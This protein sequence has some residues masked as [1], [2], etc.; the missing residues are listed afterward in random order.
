MPARLLAIDA[1]TGSC[2]AALFTPDGRQ[3]ALA[4]REWSHPA[5]RGV[6]GGATFDID[7][8]WGLI[9]ACV[10]SVMSQSH[11]HPRD[12][13]AVSATSMREGI[14]LYD[15]AGMEVWA[16]PNV[17]ARA[18]AEVAELVA[19]GDAER[20]Y[21]VAGDWVAITSAARLLWLSTH[22]PDV[23]AATRHVT[24]I[25]DWI[26]YRL[27]AV[28]VTDPSAGSS[29]GMFD[30]SARDWS[31]WVVE[32]CGMPIDRFPAVAEPGT[33]VGEVTAAA[34]RE[35]GLDAGTP[36]VLGGADTQLALLGLGCSA[37]DTVTVIGGTFWQTAITTEV[38]LVDPHMRLRTLCHAL[39]D[40]W[41]VEGIGF[42]SGLSMRWFRDAFCEPEM[43]EAADTG[44]DA[45][46]LME[47]LARQAPP[48]V[49]GVLATFSNVMDAKRWLHASPSFLQFDVTRPATSGRKECIRALEE[50]AAYVVQHHCEI[51]AQISDRHFERI[52]MAGGAA[53]GTLWPQIVAD[54]TGLEVTVPV[55]KESAALGCALL[56][57]AGVGLRPTPGE[58]SV[59]DDQIER[60]HVPDPDDHRA[61]VA[62]CHEWS[63]AYAGALELVEH[64]LVNPLWRAAGT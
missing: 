28:F 38:P 35:T 24:M 63:A 9:C 41:M 8:N 15:A 32:R 29:S 2:R 54:V 33:A 56:G 30:L 10:R 40:R 64:G 49:S 39:P 4:S 36:V 13:A 18:G 6:P 19:S 47:D 58:W 11:T 31:P 21:G 62:L 16:C 7:R 23:F 57:A 51:L 43:R 34:A 59:P 12:V 52:V 48:G 25:S 3:T 53:N 50:G 55:I 1:G 26:L 20:I 17:D 61:Y 45:Y 60:I 27:S 22:E 42:L 46:A 44:V 5:P 37:P 14:V